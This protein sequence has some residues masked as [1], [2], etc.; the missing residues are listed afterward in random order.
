MRLADF[1]YIPEITNVFNEWAYIYDPDWGGDFIEMIDMFNYFIIEPIWQTFME[2]V[3]D[4]DMENCRSSQIAILEYMGMGFE[5][6]CDDVSMQVT[7]LLILLWA[8]VRSNTPYNSRIEIHYPH[9]NMVKVSYRNSTRTRGD[10]DNVGT[11][12]ETRLFR[13]VFPSHCG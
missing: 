12:R 9:N 5:E 4:F 8:N 6:Q 11:Y 10:Y 3:R 7:E 2:Y 13:D 1:Y